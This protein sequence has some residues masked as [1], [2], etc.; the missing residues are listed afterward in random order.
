MRMRKFLGIALA[1][2]VAAGFVA[3]AASAGRVATSNLRQVAPN[4]VKAG[5]AKWR[6]TK[7]GSI[8]WAVNHAKPGDTIAIGP[9][10][11]RESVMIQKNGLTIRGAGPRL[12]LIKPPK[13]MTGKCKVN[14]ICVVGQMGD[15]GQIVS[16]TRGVQIRGVGLNNWPGMGLFAFGTAGLR[17]SDSHAFSDTEY[18]FARFDSIGGAFFENVARGSDEAG[19][20]LGD[21]MHA[22]ATVADNRS[23]GNNLGYFIRHSWGI[24][25]NHNV[26]VGNCQGVLVLDDGQPE[27]VGNITLLY[28]V[29]NKNN[30]YCSAAEGPAVRGGGILLLG[31]QDSTVAWNIVRNNTGHKINSGGIVLLSSKK[32]T[33]GSP[34][35]GNLVKRNLAYGNSPADI[36][37]DGSGSGNKIVRNSCAKSKPN[38]Y[39]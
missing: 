36:R 18:G 3:P 9:G 29:M 19:F 14:G 12:T 27:G 4:I 26:G 35:R 23:T 37:Y 39:C 24:T 2:T 10:I 17:V 31:A 1:A 33:G 7:G 8:Q 11:Y 30:R 22:H 32:L 13:K 16:R 20:Y 38:G 15:R 21:S 34:V 6:V 5:P 28:N 25:L